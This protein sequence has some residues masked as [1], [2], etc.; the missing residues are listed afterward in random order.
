VAARGED[1]IKALSGIQR[2]KTGDL[3]WGSRSRSVI[4]PPRQ[5]R[6]WRLAGQSV[7]SSHPS[8]HRHANL[9]LTCVSSYKGPEM[10]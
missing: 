6:W 5:A 3:K 10:L 9:S 4:A 2:I 8:A 7:H 1:W